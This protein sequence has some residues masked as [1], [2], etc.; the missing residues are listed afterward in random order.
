MKQNITLIMMAV[1][2]ILYI[3]L[4]Q[5]ELIRFAAHTGVLVLFVIL[6]E[7]QNKKK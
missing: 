6:I 2:V 3:L 5:N 1:Y 4:K 7:L